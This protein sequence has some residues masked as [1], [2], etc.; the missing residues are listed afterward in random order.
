L[1]RLD[2]RLEH[3]GQ[4]SDGE[5]LLVSRRTLRSMNS[6]LNNIL[7]L[8]RGRNR[9]V[10]QMHPADAEARHLGR[11]AHARVRSRTGEIEVALHLT[12]EVMPGVV[13]LPYG[14]GHDRPGS[15]LSV[16]HAHAGA[17]LNDTADERVC[18]HLRGT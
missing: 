18:H 12:T 5:L 17:S 4:A 8:A 2:R 14:W 13:S 7:R 3:G 9:C 15:R 1:Q 16:A 10:L 11:A 6:W